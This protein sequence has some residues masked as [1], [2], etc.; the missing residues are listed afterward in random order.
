M[1]EVTL[2]DIAARAGVSKS[3]I[4]SK[5]IVSFTNLFND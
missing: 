5:I 2:K 3:A 4:L 1:V